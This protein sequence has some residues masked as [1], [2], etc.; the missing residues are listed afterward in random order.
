MGTAVAYPDCQSAG[1]VASSLLGEHVRIMQKNFRCACA[2]LVPLGVKCACTCSG[3]GEVFT[4]VKKVLLEHCLPCCD[5]VCGLIVCGCC[6]VVVVLCFCCVCL[7]VDH[8]DIQSRRGAIIRLP[9]KGPWL[10]M[11]FVRACLKF[12]PR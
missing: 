5:V 10:L 9:L 8:L 2:V 3:D 4:C 12:S 11:S 7:N 6:V 1:A